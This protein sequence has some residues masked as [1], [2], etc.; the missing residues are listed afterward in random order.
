[1]PRWL[2]QGTC[3]ISPSTN[4]QYV[5]PSYVCL[6]SN[7]NLTT[8]SAPSSSDF[9]VSL[10][11]NYISVLRSDTF[12]RLS[13]LTEFG[14]GRLEHAGLVYVVPDARLP[15]RVR[16]CSDLIVLRHLH[17]HGEPV[18]DSDKLFAP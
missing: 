1:M 14:E 3:F 12:Q 6:W 15:G 11:F 9:A 10:L 16:P 7:I 2:H 4:L 5:L 18:R 8:A 17:V 13:H